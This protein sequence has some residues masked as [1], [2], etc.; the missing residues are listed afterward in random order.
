MIMV[1]ALGGCASQPLSG[2]FESSERSQI[3]GRVSEPVKFVPAIGAPVEVSK[4]LTDQLKAAASQKS[5]TI[6]DEG[7][8]WIYTVRGYLAASPEGNQS[9]IAYIWDVTQK[10]GKRVHRVTGEELVPAK[11][12]GPWASLDDATINKIALATANDLAAWLP[13]ESAPQP[14]AAR[15]RRERPQAPADSAAPGEVLTY[16]PA[17]IGAPGDGQRSLTLAIKKQLFKNGIKIT[18]TPG[19]AAYMVKGTV[20]LG[21]PQGGKQSIAIKWDVSDPNGE[22]LGTVSQENTIA[23]GALDGKWGAVADAAAGDA[24]NEVL[25]LLPKPKT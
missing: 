12:G 21:S 19:K 1:A 11:A 17:V 24:T 2:L 15:P 18:S 10:D 20:K 3:A 8:P 13:K 5:V 4:K 6:A 25:K 7:Q 9:K 23:Q 14:V 22:H 16:V